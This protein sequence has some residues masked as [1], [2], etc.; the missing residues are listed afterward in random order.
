MNWRSFHKRKIQFNPYAVQKI[1]RKAVS[2][3]IG[4]ECWIWENYKQCQIK[5]KSLNPCPG[6]KHL[7]IRPQLQS[8]EMPLFSAM[9]GKE[10]R[11]EGKRR[12]EERRR[13]ER[14]GEERRR[15]GGERERANKWNQ[16]WKRRYTTEIKRILRTYYEK[17]Y[18]KK[19]DNLGKMDTFQ[20]IYNLPKL[21]QE[22]AESLKWLITASE[23]EAVIKKRLA[24]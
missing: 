9:V 8:M 21:N 14:R 23:I 11:R 18:A 4:I 5:G 13:V 7:L 16:K 24:P 19:L 2:I 10:K 15:G 20:E 22:E 1:H 3:T 6:K 17:L 12:G